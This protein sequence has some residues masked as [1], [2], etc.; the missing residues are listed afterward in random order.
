M[1]SGAGTAL[2]LRQL[3]GL[4]TSAYII[5]TFVQH[6]Q[7]WNFS[8]TPEM[9]LSGAVTRWCRYEVMSWNSVISAGA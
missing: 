4:Q 5:I 9:R 3:P 7:H 2:V 6:A 1:E 8:H